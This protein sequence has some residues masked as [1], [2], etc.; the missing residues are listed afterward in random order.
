MM[1]SLTRSRHWRLLCGVRGLRARWLRSCRF[2]MAIASS[3]PQ[4]RLRLPTCGPCAASLTAAAQRGSR[5]AR[6]LAI[7]GACVNRAADIRLARQAEPAT[8]DAF[9][10]QLEL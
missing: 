8:R 6:L 2:C 9:G 4:S 5:S 3:T 10:E 1:R 7:E